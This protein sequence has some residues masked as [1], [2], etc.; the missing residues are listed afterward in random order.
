MR[1]QKIRT[2]LQSF[3]MRLQSFGVRLQNFRRRVQSFGML[4]QKFRIKAQKFGVEVQKNRSR[5]Q[6]LNPAWID[7]G[8]WLLFWRRFINMKTINSASAFLCAVSFLLLNLNIA[9]QSKKIPQSPF[10]ITD[11]STGKPIPEVLVLPRYSSLGGITTMSGE[12]PEKIVNERD[13]L[14]KPFV[15][16]IGEPFVLK[17]PK[18][19]GINL[20]FV[21]LVPK[22]RSLDGVVIVASKYRPLWLWTSELFETNDKRKLQMTPASDEQWS[23][24]LEK[25]LIPLTKEETLP[26]ED[27]PFWGLFEKSRILHIYYNK[28]E[29][30]LVRGFLSGK[31][32]D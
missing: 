29:R 19:A 17:R 1:L 32:T 23:L 3:G 24:I 6:K 13:Y 15:Y 18:S 31:E 11:A 16:R 5:V 10:Q 12:G 14:D 2:R 27:Y 30:A 26:I 21:A 7:L 22:G 25:K 9:A 20:I 28:K 4:V 8:E